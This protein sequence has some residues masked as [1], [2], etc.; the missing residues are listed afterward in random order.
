MGSYRTPIETFGV[1]VKMGTRRK[2]GM[3]NGKEQMAKNGARENGK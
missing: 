1:D 3:A 2:C